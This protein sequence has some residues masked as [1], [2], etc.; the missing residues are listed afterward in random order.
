MPLLTV[1]PAPLLVEACRCVVTV[2]LERV[3][4]DEVFDE[5]APL[6]GGGVFEAE[7]GHAVAGRAAAPAFVAVFRADVAAGDELQ[8]RVGA[9]V[10]I[11][12]VAL[13][14]VEAGVGWGDGVFADVA[15]SA[16]GERD[17]S[18]RLRQANQVRA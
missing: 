18:F 13:R 9:D 1:L 2:V 6:A 5:H 14:A 11:P 8:V 3:P 16:Q 15:L 4:A 10:E 17:I 12:V 7:D